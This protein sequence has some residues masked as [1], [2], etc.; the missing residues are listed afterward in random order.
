MSFNLNSLWLDWRAK[1]PDG[2]PNPS[3]DYH[4]VLLKELCLE[5][6]IDKDTTDSV[7][8]FLEKKEKTGYTHKSHDIYVK[9]ADADNPN[10]QRYKKV[11]DKFVK[12]DKKDKVVKKGKPKGDGVFDKPTVKKAPPLA[13][14]KTKKA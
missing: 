14:K 9:D 2:T 6:G 11:G 5:K 10:A 13:L 3:N 4:L 12:V 8:L 1:V 7:I